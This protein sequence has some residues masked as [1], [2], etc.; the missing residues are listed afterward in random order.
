MI[1]PFQGNVDVTSKNGTDHE[2]NLNNTENPEDFTNDKKGFGHSSPIK[3][4][5]I[6]AMASKM[7]SKDFMSSKSIKWKQKE[8]KKEN[9][10]FVSSKYTDLCRLP[11]NNA[12]QQENDEMVF[13]NR[14][15]RHR[16]GMKSQ[17]HHHHLPTAP[18]TS[19]SHSSPSS[20]QQQRQHRNKCDSPSVCNDANCQKERKCYCCCEY[21][22]DSEKTK[23]LETCKTALNL[24][25]QL[26]KY[27]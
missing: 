1:L 10:E 4:K 8:N 3:N 18:L 12:K 5:L 16:R 24:F 15:G 2:K 11:R 22:E 27:I 26:L 9:T 17:F 14:G 23:E 6:A 13:F 19:F 21:I 25:K 20:Q 7:N